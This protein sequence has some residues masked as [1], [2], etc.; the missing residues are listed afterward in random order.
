MIK[1]HKFLKKLK[2]AIGRSPVTALLGLRQCGKTPLARYLGGQK[3]A[4]YYDLES[5]VDLRRL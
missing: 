1:R 5:Q 4:D 3:S 2:T